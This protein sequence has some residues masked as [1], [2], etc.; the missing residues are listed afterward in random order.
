MDNMHVL[1][2]DVKATRNF[3]QNV[4]VDNDRIIVD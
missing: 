2:I 4:I 3:C 1:Y